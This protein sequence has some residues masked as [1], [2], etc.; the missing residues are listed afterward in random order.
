M[1]KCFEPEEARWYHW[2]LNGA[3]VYLRR[4]GD[5]WRTALR[6]VL[7]QEAT[8]S[9]DGPEPDRAPRNLPEYSAV[10]VGRQVVLRPWFYE[11]PY[12]V[13]FRDRI[14]LMPET[15]TR[16]DLALP[17]VL[18]LE[19]AGGLELTRFTPFLLPETWSGEDTMSGFLGVSLSVPSPPWSVTGASSFIHGEIIFRNQTKTILDIDRLVLYTDSLNVYKKEGDLRCETVVVDTNSNGE[20]R[21][22]P[23]PGTPDG[24]EAIPVA[25]KNGMGNILIRRSADLIKNI[26]GR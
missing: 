1:W 21:I 22:N 26:A 19:L 6:S 18:R 25:R 11:K 4:E 14:R 12:C 7:F 23:R 3:E 16:L 13:N 2:N 17:P 5:E 10:G 8:P 9:A 24:Y 15:E 20:L